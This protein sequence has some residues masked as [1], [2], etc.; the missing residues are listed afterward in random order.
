[1]AGLL[2]LPKEPRNVKPPLVRPR[3]F[4]F[5]VFGTIVDWRAGLR[6]ALGSRAL[7]EA[8]FDRLID[9]QGELEQGPFRPYAEIVADS[10]VR[11]LSLSR[12][13]AERVGAE[14]G[15]WPLFPDSAAALRR[16]ARIAPRAATTN[17]D[18]AHGEDVQRTLGHRLPRWICAEDARAHKPHRR[19]L[20]GAAARLPGPVGRRGG[21][22]APPAAFG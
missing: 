2:P 15:T 8:D 5:D 13:E 3:L 11:V 1:M 18:R 16:L 14:A 9:V 20:G 12:A 4:T 6:K 21:R 17:S 22:R 7:S 19:G 10:L